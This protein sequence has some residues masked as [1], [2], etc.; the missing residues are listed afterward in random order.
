MN[1][2]TLD[3]LLLLA[4][5]GHLG[6][7]FAA[8]LVPFALDWKK[9]LGETQSSAKSILLTADVERVGYRWSAGTCVLVAALLLRLPLAG[10]Y[11]ALCFRESLME[12]LVASYG[13]L[14]TFRGTGEFERLCE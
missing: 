3:T 14:P 13:E 7:L 6:V 4:G 10:F 11:K 5:L 8:S 12:L 2:P 9:E 1:L